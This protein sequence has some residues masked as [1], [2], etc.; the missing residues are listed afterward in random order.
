MAKNIKESKPRI[1]HV[2]TKKGFGYEAAEKDRIRWHA[3]ESMVKVL[4]DIAPKSKFPKYQEVAG[5]N[6]IGISRAG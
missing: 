4:P 6:T 5:K 1:L 2:R 3:T